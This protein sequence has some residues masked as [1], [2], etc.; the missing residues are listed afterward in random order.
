MA[1]LER[2]LRSSLRRAI[3][4]LS[5]AEIAAR[6]GPAEAQYSQELTLGLEG[7]AGEIACGATIVDQ[8]ANDDNPDVG[9]ARVRLVWNDLVGETGYVVQRSNGASYT[10]CTGGCFQQDA[11]TTSSTAGTPNTLTQTYRIMAHFGHVHSGHPGFDFDVELPGD[12]LSNTCTVTF[13]VPGD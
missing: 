7:P 4:S 3:V 8:D 9:N 2:I 1:E 13:V 11:D 10:G 12:V 6:L 5:G